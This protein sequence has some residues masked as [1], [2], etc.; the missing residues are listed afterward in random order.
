MAV[1]RSTGRI[2][3]GCRRRSPPPS[4]EPRKL[5]PPGGGPRPVCCSKSRSPNATSREPTTGSD[6]RCGGWVPPTSPST[7]G[8]RRSRRT[9]L[10]ARQRGPQRSRSGWR[11]STCRSTGTTPLPTDGS[12]GPS[13][14]SARRRRAP[15]ADWISPGRNERG[16]PRRKRSWPSERS[17]RRR[18]SA[19]L[20]SRSPPSPSSGSPRSSSVGSTMA[21]IGST[22]RW[23]RQ[24][25][26]RRT[27]SRRSPKHAAASS[28][29]A[30]PRETPVG[31]S[32]GHASSPGSSSAEAIFP[33]WGSVARATLRCSPPQAATRKR[34]ASSS[35][36]RVNCE[37]R[38]T[39]PDA[40]TRPSSSRRS[41]FGR[42]GSTRLRP[43]WTVVRAC[44]RRRCPPPSSTW[45]VATPRSR[46]P[47]CCAGS[48]TS[49]VTACS[50]VRSSRA[51]SRRT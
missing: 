15:G 1:A 18:R 29:P 25:A 50:R 26:A 37:E 6:A 9:R 42:G 36:R 33:C 17:R 8:N 45:H 41:G 46:S 7:I 13:G 30:M 39:V 5:S 21:S 48:A 11:V 40:W 51:W 22:K 49:G 24:P 3:D 43:C 28:R 44:R 34:S 38:G 23:P 27:C 14:S 4:H 31:W 20:I 19:T 10:P 2:T 32:S 16:T 35:P 12:R 47:C